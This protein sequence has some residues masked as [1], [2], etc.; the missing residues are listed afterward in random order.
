MTIRNL[1]KNK[2][3]KIEDVFAKNEVQF[4][5]IFGFDL[6]SV[7]NPNG[8]MND[9]LAAIIVAKHKLTGNAML[10]DLQVKIIRHY[11]WTAWDFIV[12]LERQIEEV[13]PKNV[14]SK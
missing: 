11:G 12:K 14:S 10:K 3:K 4:R 13:T 1:F 7:W 2:S 9:R 8:L 6:K 5:Q